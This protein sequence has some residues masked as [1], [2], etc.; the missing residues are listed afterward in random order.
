MEAGKEGQPQAPEG[1]GAPAPNDWETYMQ[2]AVDK[3][4]AGAT[5]TPVQEQRSQDYYENFAEGQNVFDAQDAKHADI[6]DQ[7]FDRM[8]RQRESFKG[9]EHE[10]DFSDK[11][12]ADKLRAFDD[13]YHAKQDANIDA[14]ATAE[15]SQADDDAEKI[16][17][18]YDKEAQQNPAE[19]ERRN[20]AVELFKEKYK[21]KFPDREMMSDDEIDALYKQGVVDAA[22]E[23]VDAAEEARVGSTGGAEGQTA[24]KPAEKSANELAEAKKEAMRTVGA[25][26]ISGEM[27]DTH[28]AQVFG[29][30]LAETWARENSAETRAEKKKRKK[31]ERE[32]RKYLKKNYPGLKMPTPVDFDAMFRRAVEQVSQGKR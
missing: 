12:I 10:N 14:T 11:A 22:E 30:A 21:A 32:M 31:A 9:T 24:E 25:E 16:F 19:T 26:Q 13:R 6:R 29:R 3:M 4:T 27:V 18:Q 7:Y 2:N 17:E 15:S 28:D 8:M 1:Q 23:A 20:R 5:D